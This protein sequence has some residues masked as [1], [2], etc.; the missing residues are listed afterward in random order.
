MWLGFIGGLAL[1]FLGADLL[2]RGAVALAAKLRISPAVI[3]LTVVAYGTSLPEAGAS[4]LAGARGVPGVAI[5][6]VVGSNV[7]NVLL[8]LGATAI[9]RALPLR[10]ELRGQIPL[11]VGLSLAVPLSLLFGG[12]SRL[13]AALLL[14]AIIA[15]AWINIARSRSKSRNAEVGD[16]D[17][18]AEVPADMQRSWLSIAALTI[19]GMATVPFGAHLFIDAAA[20][21][22]RN[23]GV[24][25]ATIGLTLV[26]LATSLP[27][28]ATSI[29]SAVKGE[30]GLAVGNVVGSN[31]FN[32]L[33]VLAVAGLIHPLEADI[34]SF[35]WDIAVMMGAA[36]LLWGLERWTDAIRRPAG[37]A[38]LTAYVAYVTMLAPAHPAG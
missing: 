36:L 38:M 30:V 8:V 4:A 17:H 31:C 37:I 9:I 7:A 21:V 19:F 2:V 3:G 26:A 33:G 34:S 25:D 18:V 32:A 24:S 1:L 15:Y 29:A 11:M 13:D 10:D 27:E 12:V 6:N 16:P 14:G 23:L 28:L 22:A 35:R 20:E 5:G